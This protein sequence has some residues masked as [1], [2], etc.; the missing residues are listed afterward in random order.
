MTTPTSHGVCLYSIGR[1]LPQF[2][3]SGLIGCLI[4]FLD[5]FQ[6]LGKDLEPLNS[7]Y[8]GTFRTDIDR[9]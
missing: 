6:C 3:I 1:K 4:I 2:S 8:L 9:N 5:S 7:G